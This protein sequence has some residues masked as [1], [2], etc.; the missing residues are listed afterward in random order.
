MNKKK[1][2]V[3][4]VAAILLTSCSFDDKTGIWTGDKEEKR[5]I[6][7]LQ[8]R[9]NEIIDIDKIYSS[10]NA[11]SREVLLANNIVISKPKKNSSWETSNLNLQNYIGNLYLSGIG[12]NFLKKRIGKNGKLLRRFSMSSFS[13]VI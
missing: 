8:K 7:D 13:M 5:R 3:F 4:I 10:E 6:S 9:Q 1:I 11:F 12:N 2:L